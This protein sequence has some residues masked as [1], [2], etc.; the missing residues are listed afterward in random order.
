MSSSLADRPR[1][2]GVH[3]DDWGRPG[4]R[5]GAM[6]PVREVRWRPTGSSLGDLSRYARTWTSRPVEQEVP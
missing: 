4:P 3:R 6:A 2:V 5:T 1:T